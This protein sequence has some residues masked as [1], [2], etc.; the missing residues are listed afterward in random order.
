[1][2]TR[3]WLVSWIQRP[4]LPLSPAWLK[5]L[6]AAVNVIEISAPVFQYCTLHPCAQETCSFMEWE[7]QK[8]EKTAPRPN[9]DSR[10]L[11]SPNL[12]GL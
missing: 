7:A 4:A 9:K 8:R 10:T 12:I 3:I 1:M 5:V 6:L 2:L 11:N